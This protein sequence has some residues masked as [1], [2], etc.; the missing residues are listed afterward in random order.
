MERLEM[1][2]EQGQRFLGMEQLRDCALIR[3]EREEEEAEP[4]SE[5]ACE[6]EEEEQPL[7][8]MEVRCV[9]ASGVEAAGHDLR[10]LS[11]AAW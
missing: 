7:L 3:R 6:P 8:E 4:H 9:K 2:G 5:E 10:Y 11:P 1:K